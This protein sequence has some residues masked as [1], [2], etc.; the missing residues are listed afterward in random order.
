M[1]NPAGFGEKIWKLSQIGSLLFLSPPHQK[2]KYLSSVDQISAL[3]SHLPNPCQTV[4]KILK[5]NDR[6]REGNAPREELLTPNVLLM[7]LGKVVFF[8]KKN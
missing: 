2:K 1:R 6:L 5:E 3:S 4:S 7:F 8:L